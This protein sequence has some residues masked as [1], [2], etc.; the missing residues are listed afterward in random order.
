MPDKTAEAFV[1]HPLLPHLN[2]RVYRTGDIARRDEHGVFHFLGRRDDLVK[3]RGYR[4]ELNEIEIALGG[5]SDK[6]DQFAAVAVPD[7]LIENKLYGAVVF[8]DGIEMTVDEIKKFC[9]TRIPQY[10]VPDEILILDDLPQT[11]SGKVSRKLLR[12]FIQE[13]YPAE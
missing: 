5:L 8:K 9:A 13:N 10:M 3:S 11:S 4:I 12:Q 7:P 6:L 2:E 1:N